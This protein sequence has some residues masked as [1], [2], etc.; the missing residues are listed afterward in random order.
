[1]EKILI[2]ACLLIFVSTAL[3][4]GAVIALYRLSM[5]VEAE[6]HVYDDHH[7]AIKKGQQVH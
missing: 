5:N 1:M 2:F 3:K 6:D 7:F 4:I